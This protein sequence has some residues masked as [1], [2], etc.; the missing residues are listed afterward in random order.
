MEEQMKSLLSDEKECFVCK[1]TQ[2]LHRHHVYAGANRKI[3]EQYGCWVYLCMYHHNGSKHGVHYDR[4][5]DLK[6]R[7]ECQIAFEEKYGEQ[8]YWEKIGRNYK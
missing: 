8:T 7:R 6:L 3:S 1:T 2:N 4:E 5:L